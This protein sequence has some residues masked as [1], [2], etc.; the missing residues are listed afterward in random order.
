MPRSNALARGLALALLG[1]GAWSFVG[2][3]SPKAAVTQMQGWRWDRMLASGDWSLDT[4]EGF[5]IGETGFHDSQKAQGYRY[6]MTAY[7]EDLTNSIDCPGLLQLGPLKFR[8]F[9]A[10]GGSGVNDKLRELKK[11]IVA[12][13]LDDPKKLEE[14]EY[15]LKRYGHKRWSIKN[16]NQA[17]NGKGES[18]LLRG[19]AAW[20]GYDPLKEEKGKSWVEPDFGKP[21]LIMKQGSMGA[22]ERNWISKEQNDIEVA[23]GKVSNSAPIPGAE[24]GGWD[25]KLLE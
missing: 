7:G 13:G 6:R 22:L 25:P 15:W 16:V 5:W 21:W 17:N 11:Q 14:N 8:L 18:G 19:L 12:T 23:A 3:G 2:S 24:V 9:D 4:A 1:A 20:S 10:V